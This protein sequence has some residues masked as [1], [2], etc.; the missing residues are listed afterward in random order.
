MTGEGPTTR[1][2]LL[3]ALPVLQDPNFERAVL[4]VLEHAPEG[5]LALVLNRPSETSVAEPLPEWTGPVVEPGV[6]FVGGPVG[7][8]GAIGLAR[9]STRRTAAGWTPLLDRWGTVDLHRTPEEVEADLDG[10]RV[11]AGHA[12]WTS[13]QLDEELA[14]GAWAV[15]DALPED[16]LTVDPGRLWRAVL[17]RQGGRMAWLAN[18]PPDPSVN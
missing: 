13:G 2:R 15:V 6:V 3:V 12:G 10:V 1:G 14:E 7:T 11:F 17:R 18:H 8:D 4:L 5:A 9:S 16:P